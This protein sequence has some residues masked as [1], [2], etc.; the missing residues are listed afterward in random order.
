MTGESYARA[1]RAGIAALQEIAARQA[2]ARPP[3]RCGCPAAGHEHYRSGGVTECAW[4][5]WCKEYRPR[6][7]PVRTRITL[8]L[9]LTLRSWRARFVPVPRPSGP[10]PDATHSKEN[11]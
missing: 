10:G 5:W 9:A 2:G 4:C 1:Q 8:W 11:A 3:C 6:Q 7:L